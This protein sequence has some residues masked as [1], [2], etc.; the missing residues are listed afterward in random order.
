MGTD[1]LLRQRSPGASRFFVAS[2][3]CHAPNGVNTGDQPFPR[4][5]MARPPSLGTATAF[6]AA[7]TPSA[8][9]IGCAC[10]HGT[11]TRVDSSATL[12]VVAPSGPSRAASPLLWAARL[13]RPLSALSR[14]A[15]SLA[16]PSAPRRSLERCRRVDILKPLQVSVSYKRSPR[17]SQVRSLRVAPTSRCSSSR[18]RRGLGAACGDAVRRGLGTRGASLTAMHI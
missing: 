18:S 9:R 11:R 13:R 1:L 12:R 10:G 3:P 8:L 16:P 2:P 17:R 15:D 4:H 14:P 7:R 5:A 6:S